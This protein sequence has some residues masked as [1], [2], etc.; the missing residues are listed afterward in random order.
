MRVKTHLIE[1]QEILII[2]TLQRERMLTFVGR[3]GQQEF[4]CPCANNEQLTLISY[5]QCV[6]FF[7]MLLLTV[8]LFMYLF[9]QN[10]GKEHIYF[11]PENK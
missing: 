7:P 2:L 10:P 3:A 9:I 11:W 1:I 6:L 5:I 4:T 8:Q